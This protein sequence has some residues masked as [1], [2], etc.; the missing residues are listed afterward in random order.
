M[1]IIKVTHTH[2]QSETIVLTMTIPKAKPEV[3]KR[4]PREA[5]STSVSMSVLLYALRVNKE[6]QI[7][8]LFPDKGGLGVQV[9]SKTASIYDIM[10]HYIPAYTRVSLVSYCI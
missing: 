3:G 7:E 5:T 8:R 2:T 9:K 1:L 10:T 4:M 6:N